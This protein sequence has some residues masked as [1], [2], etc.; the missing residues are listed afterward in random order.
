MVKPTEYSREFAVLTRAPKGE[1]GEPFSADGDSGSV[2]INS[3]CTVVGMV[4]SGGGTLA[5]SNTTYVTPIAFLVEHLRE[6]GF[7]PDIFPG[8][9]SISSSG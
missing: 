4:T 8:A 1:R 5:E 7:E 3:S 6:H 2:V 9:G